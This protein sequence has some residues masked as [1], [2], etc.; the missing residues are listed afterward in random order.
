[1]DWYFRGIGEPGGSAKMGFNGLKLYLRARRFS[2]TGLRAVRV[3]R[4]FAFSLDLCL[5]SLLSI[6]SFDLTP[7]FSHFKDCTNDRGPN[8]LD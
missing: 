8:K 6:S 2:A 5:H 7:K 3:V 1:M 4:L